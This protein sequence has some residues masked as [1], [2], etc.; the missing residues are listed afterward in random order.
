MSLKSPRER[1]ETEEETQIK[2]PKIDEEEEDEKN[3]NDNNEDDDDESKPWAKLISLTDGFENI[4]ISKRQHSI[5][6][7]R[8]CDTV[9]NG[10]EGMS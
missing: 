5:G 9:G 1:D 3:D 4:L 7:S 2:R 6:R 10:T 8:T